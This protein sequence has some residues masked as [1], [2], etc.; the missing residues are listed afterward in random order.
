M[1]VIEPGS[2]KPYK[3]INDTLRVTIGWHALESSNAAAMR[4]YP[5]HPEQKHCMISKDIW[6]KSLW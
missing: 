2:R 4:E 1:E 3:H 6:A 5:M